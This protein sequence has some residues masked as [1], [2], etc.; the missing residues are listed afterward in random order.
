METY[1]FQAQITRVAPVGVVPDGLRIDV[2]FAGSMSDGPLTGS[3]IEG[4]DYLLIR[5]D[6]IGVIEAREYVVVE[7]GGA[8]SLRVDGYIVPPFPMPPLEALLDPAFEWPDADLPL[9]GAARMS[10]ASAQLAAVN[11]N[12]YAFNGAVNMAR[13]SLVVAGRRIAG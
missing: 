6:G 5:A 10:A 8:L 11:Q 9:H 3:P 4:V 7:G 13:G 2:G 12:V 1:G